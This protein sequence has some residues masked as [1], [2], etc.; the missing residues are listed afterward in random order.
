MASKNVPQIRTIIAGVG[1]Y[2]PKKRVTNADLA[3]TVDTNDEWI[4]ERTGITQR[5]IIAEEECTSD[6]AAA[7]ARKAL[8]AANLKPRDIDLILVATTT[9]DNTFPA[10]AARVQALLEVGPAAV[11]DVQAV[12]A[13]FAYAL[14]TADALLKSGN[15][16][17]ALVIGADALSR[18]VD[19]KDRNTCV[20]FGDGAGAVV[21]S[22]QIAA[23]RGILSA[24][25]DADGATRD[26][27]YVDGGP[28]QAGGKTGF[29][30]MQG[31]EVFKMAA[32]K[33]AESVEI[34]LTRAGVTAAEVDWVV[35]HQANQRILDATMKK[36]GLP[37]EKLISTVALHANTSAASIPLA[38]AVAA[39]DGRIKQGD[40]VVL[41]AIGGGMSWGTVVVRW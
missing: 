15:Y 36:L 34:A 17:H 35:P 33:M 14:A 29:I 38:L 41:T 37:G 7:A 40:L 22:A 19:W 32:T 25:L 9:P 8:E 24:H 11:M 2:L 12:C 4:R 27:L 5:H 20:L 28:G 1:S 6:M 26:I 13:G 16:Q 21:L 23:E 31:R 30:H 10:T 3:K 39:K 18:I